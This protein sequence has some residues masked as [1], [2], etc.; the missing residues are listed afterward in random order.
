MKSLLLTL[1]FINDIV[2]LD[3]KI[4]HSAKRIEESKTIETANRAIEWARQQNITVAHVKVGFNEHYLEC[5]KDSPL[6]SAAEKYGA[7]KLNGWG[8]EFHEKLA[9]QPNDPVIVKHRVNAFYGTDLE[10]L[11]RVQKIDT[12]ILCGVATNYAVEHCSREAHDRDYRVIVL[13][14]ACQTA[15]D[16]MHQAS[17][18]SLDRLARVIT[19]D[20]LIQGKN[21]GE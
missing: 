7:L 1:D 13:S 21:D 5:P 3:G 8:T 11:L 4:A 17:L 9:V 15:S 18:T 14:D 12:L 6:F 2:H 10:T 20:E 19:V 16:E